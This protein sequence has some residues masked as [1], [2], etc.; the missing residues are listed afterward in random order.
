MDPTAMKPFGLALSDYFSG[1]EAAEF[2]IYRDDSWPS[3]IP[4]AIFFREATEISVDKV[5]L[6]NCRGN[7]LD[8]GA[9]TGIHSLYLKNKGFTVCS[10]DISPEACEIMRKRGLKDVRCV[11]VTG[12]QAGPFDTL[13]ILGR[14]IGMVE[15]I[16]G[17]DYFLKRMRGLVKNDGKD[18][19]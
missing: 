9:G 13:L 19:A 11:D 18:S 2:Y 16:D 1:D 4:A 5:A 17:L 6:D 15:T 14:G 12:V 3:R 10:I 8:V 7:V